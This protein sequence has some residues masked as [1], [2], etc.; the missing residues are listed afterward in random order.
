MSNTGDIDGWAVFR[1]GPFN[2]YAPTQPL[3]GGGS[4]IVGMYRRRLLAA[5]TCSNR[6]P[7]AACKSC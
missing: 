5:V 6:F 7:A 1:D 4:A 2:G 3:A